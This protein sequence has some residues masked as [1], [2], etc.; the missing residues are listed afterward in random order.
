MNSCRHSKVE[1]LFLYKKWLEWDCCSR[2]DWTLTPHFFLSCARD[3]ISP[4]DWVSGASV[5]MSPSLLLLYMCS[6]VCASILVCDILKM[7]TIHVSP[8]VCIDR[9][10]SNDLAPSFVSSCGDLSVIIVTILLFAPSI[11][12]LTSSVNI[13]ASDLYVS[14]EH[15]LDILYRLILNRRCNTLAPQIFHI[16]SN[17]ATAM[18]ILLRTSAIWPP[19]TSKIASR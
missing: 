7:W 9:T 5:R 8:L 14:I 10:K 17:L 2:P 12:L 11:I 15:T 6:T 3:R 4:H 16:L 1:F 19:P 18:F 13:H